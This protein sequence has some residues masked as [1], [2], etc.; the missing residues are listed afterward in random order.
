MLTEQALTEPAGAIDWLPQDDALVI[1]SWSGQGRVWNVATKEFIRE[2]RLDKDAVSAAAWSPD[3]PL[4][5]PW[6]AEQLFRRSVV[7]LEENKEAGP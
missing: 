1:A 6:L 7:P 4:V 3:C 2:F 5:T